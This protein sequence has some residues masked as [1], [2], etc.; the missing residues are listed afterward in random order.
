MTPT[1][2]SLKWL[3]ENGWDACVVEKFNIYAKVRQDA[4]GYGDIL[5]CHP[6]R[7]IALVQTTSTGNMSARRK[8]IAGIPQSARWMKCGG[9]VIIHGWAKRGPRGKAKRWTLSEEIL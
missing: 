7:G 3:R 2:R 4:F 8:K 9:M 6:L 1:S 5:A